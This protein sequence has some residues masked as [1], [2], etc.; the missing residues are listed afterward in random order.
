M[1]FRLNQNNFFHRGSGND[2]SKS[3]GKGSNSSF[4]RYPTREDS[5]DS[6]KDD[7]T[8]NKSTQQQ[9]SEKPK[10]DKGREHNG[11][12]H[13]NGSVDDITKMLL[14]YHSTR[15]KECKRLANSTDTNETES[16]GSVS[17]EAKTESPEAS[18]KS[19]R[20]NY[21]YRSSYSRERTHDRHK[22]KS[23]R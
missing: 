11:P 9:S 1:A 14:K 13:Q 23:D 21:S 16:K 4:E 8:N 20:Y 18:H 19:Y 7:S 3:Y 15:F 2:S 6:S 22:F 10:D 5:K 17:P 12:G